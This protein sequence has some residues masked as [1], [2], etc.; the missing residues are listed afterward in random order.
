[1]LLNDECL[2]KFLSTF[3]TFDENVEKFA[4]LRNFRSQKE[5]GPYYVEFDGRTDGI[6]R[7]KANPNGTAYELNGA[8][9][10][11]CYNPA[12]SVSEVVENSMKN[13][14]DGTGKGIVDYRP[15][16]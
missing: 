12:T 10:R 3:L 11:G 13:T 7:V 9:V 8:A 16:C 6:F 2:R 1:M 4:K 14:N 5:C 15:N